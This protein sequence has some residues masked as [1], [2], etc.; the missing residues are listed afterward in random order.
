LP[1]ATAE[2][3]L[4]TLGP[5]A[6]PTG[7]P[8]EALSAT[9]N[10]LHLEKESCAV[11]VPAPTVMLKL[12]LGFL[13]LSEPLNVCV[14]IAGGGGGG[15]GAEVTTPV[16]ADEALADPAEFDAVTATTTVD[17]T[18]AVWTGYDEEIALEMG[19]QFRR[20]RG[21]L[22][23]AWSFLSPRRDLGPR[24]WR[25]VVWAVIGAVRGA[26]RALV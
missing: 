21:G 14:C 13:A 16:G 24:G 7:A 22:M 5:V 4:T 17:P 26:L 25:R 15:A 19:E 1:A 11:A 23:A 8:L 20:R 2:T 6:V 10:L 12:R 9:L 18:S 3:R